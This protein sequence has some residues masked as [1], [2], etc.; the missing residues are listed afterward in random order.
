MVKISNRLKMAASLV[1]EGSILADIGTDHAYVPIYLLQQKK[2]LSAIAMDIHAGPLERAKEHISFF[3]LENVIQTRLSD[4]AAAL[5]PH[6]ADSILIAGMGGGLVIH[7]LKD[8]QEVCKAA[9]ELILQPQSELEAVRIFLQNEGYGILAEEMVFEDGKFYPMMK[10]RFHGISKKA[11]EPQKLAN[12]YGGLLLQKRHPVL[13]NYLE[14]ERTLFLQIKENL[15][16]QP[17]SEKIRTRRLEVEETLK[18]NQLALEF[19]YESAK[20]LLK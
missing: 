1:T 4:G 19:Y 6:E 16:N 9:Q 12:L 8:G 11:D 2:I 18:Y 14:K 15:E 3:G 7:I 5:K 20:K 10:V 17:Q 13:K